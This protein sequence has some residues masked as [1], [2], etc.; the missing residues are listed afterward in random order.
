MTASPTRIKAHHVLGDVAEYADRCKQL[1]PPPPPPVPITIE[2]V[3]AWDIH[4]DV[5]EAAK[6]CPDKGEAVLTAYLALRYER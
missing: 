1:Q 2:T 4:P 3:N 6:L 5:L